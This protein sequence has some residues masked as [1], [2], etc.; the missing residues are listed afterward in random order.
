MKS[1][2]YWAL[3][4]YRIEKQQ[5]R[6]RISQLRERFADGILPPPGSPPFKYRPAFMVAGWRP[7]SQA[8]EAEASRRSAIHRVD[9]EY[10]SP[11]EPLALGEFASGVHQLEMR[12]ACRWCRDG[13]GIWVQGAQPISAEEWGPHGYSVSSLPDGLMLTREDRELLARI[14]KKSPGRN[15]GRPPIGE[16]A[17]TEAK[18][19]RRSR[20]RR[21]VIAPVRGSQP[22]TVAPVP[23][24][25]AVPGT[26]SGYESLNIEIEQ[27][28]TNLLDVEL[29]ERYHQYLGEALERLMAAPPDY[30]LTREEFTIVAAAGVLGR[31]LLPM[32]YH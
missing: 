6:I 21:A 11:R 31:R 1:E 3:V 30:I 8:E 9:W 13:R 22:G 4:R 19:Q 5:N 17:M 12:D 25:P 20:A 10:P 23:L 18:R 2:R 26:Y 7:V 16:R 32:E 24:G 15:R 28:I 14:L 29:A 27:M